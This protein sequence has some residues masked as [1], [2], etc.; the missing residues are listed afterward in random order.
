MACSDRKSRR[1]LLST[2]EVQWSTTTS[3]GM[4]DIVC[5]TGSVPAI[6]LRFITVSMLLALAAIVRKG[7]R[8]D[9]KSTRL[10]SSHSQISYAVFCLKKKPDDLEYQFGHRVARPFSLDLGFVLVRLRVLL[11]MTFQPRHVQPHPSRPYLGPERM[12][13]PTH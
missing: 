13:R 11:A 1:E 8:R 3:D 2:A 10:N 5:S 12:H 6:A 9:R 4:C 7:F